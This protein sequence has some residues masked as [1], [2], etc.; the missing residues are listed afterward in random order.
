MDHVVPG[1]LRRL[2]EADIIDMAGLKS[3]ALGQEYYRI[4]AVHT[5]L[6]QGSQITGIVDLPTATGNDAPG[7]RSSGIAEIADITHEK[8]A[9]PANSL[10]QASRAQGVKT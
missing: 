3:A 9:S 10:E 4:G 8:A 7:T 2:R 5:T 6:Y 1:P